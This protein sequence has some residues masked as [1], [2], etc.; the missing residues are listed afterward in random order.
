MGIKILKHTHLAKSVKSKRKKMELSE[1]TRLNNLYH[2]SLPWEQEPIYSV[3][4]H[5]SD[6]FCTGVVWNDKAKNWQYLIYSNLDQINRNVW[7]F[8]KD[9]KNPM[10]EFTQGLGKFNVGDLV[11][12]TWMPTNE[13]SLVRG[14]ILCTEKVLYSVNMINN[15]MIYPMWL[16]EAD[17]MLIDPSTMS[18]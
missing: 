10:P 5:N 7:I 11:A 18:M 16:D 15:G 17:I 2:R 13:F 8:E 9:L 12:F 14:K 6:I 4:S 3:G 1:I